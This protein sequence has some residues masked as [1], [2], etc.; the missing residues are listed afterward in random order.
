MDEKK[1]FE[2]IK[3]MVVDTLQ[4]DG[5]VTMN[6][7]FADDLQADSLDVVELTMALEEK[8]GITIPDEELPNIK[9]GGDSVRYIVKNGDR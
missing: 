7:S 4:F 5:D 2:D 8:Y 6:S 3:A 9:T 1:I